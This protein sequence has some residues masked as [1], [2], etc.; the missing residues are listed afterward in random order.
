MRQRKR[1]RRAPQVPGAEKGQG[2]S[3]GRGLLINV[4]SGDFFLGDFGGVP[5]GG[6]G[7]YIYPPYPYTY[8]KRP[9]Q[10]LNLRR[11]KALPTYHSHLRLYAR[12]PL[13]PP[14]GGKWEKSANPG[15]GKM[16]K[17]GKIAPRGAPQDPTDRKTDPRKN[18]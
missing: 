1:L 17:M 10:S 8:T 5:G 12:Y 18:G 11:S 3:P 15:I 14:G 6:L 2:K 9:L 4:F 16:P 13:D 7:P